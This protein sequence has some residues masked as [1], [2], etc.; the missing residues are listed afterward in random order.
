MKTY[1]SGVMALSALAQAIPVDDWILL[2]TKPD[3]EE[4]RQ[5]KLAYRRYIRH[6]LYDVG[7]GRFTNLPPEQH[8]LVLDACRESYERYLFK[9]K[10]EGRTPKPFRNTADGFIKWW[11]SSQ[12]AQ[13]VR[14]DIP[15]KLR[16]YDQSGRIAEVPELYEEARM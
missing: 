13:Y 7:K 6:L 9:C 3:P 2:P 1:S 16:E 11:K 5:E 4:L 14:C 10:V 8:K 12:R 15:R